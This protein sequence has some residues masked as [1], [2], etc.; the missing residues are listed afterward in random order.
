VVIASTTSLVVVSFFKRDSLLMKSE[1][2]AKWASLEFLPCFSQK[3][4][5]LTWF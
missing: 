5:R 2:Q 4:L 3:K 1:I